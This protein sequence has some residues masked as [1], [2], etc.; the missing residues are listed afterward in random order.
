MTHELL[1]VKTK[2][3]S[4]FFTDRRDKTSPQRMR[5]SFIIAITVFFILQY[6]ISTRFGTLVYNFADWESQHYRIPEYFRNLFYTT[7]DFFPDFGANI[8]AGQNIYNLS[9]YGLYN[10]VILLSYLLPFVPMDIYI[11][12]STGVLV[13]VSILLFYRWSLSHF[14]HYIAEI[15]TVLFMTASPVIFHTHRHMMFINYMPFLILALIGTER[16]FAKRKKGLFIISVCLICLMSYFYSIGAI[17]A[18]AVYGIYCYIKLNSKIKVKDICKEGLKFASLTVLGVAMAAFLLIPTFL[19]LL[20][21]RGDSSAVI[22]FSSLFIPDFNITKILYS[23]YSPGVTAITLYGIIYGIIKLKREKRFL[24]VILILPLFFPLVLFILNGGM[25][26]DGKVLIPM[27]PLYLF[28]TASFLTDIFDKKKI[29]RCAVIIS[30][31]IVLLYVIIKDPPLSVLTDPLITVTALIMFDKYGKRKLIIIPV[32]FI[33]MIACLIAQ[34]NDTLTARNKLK[35]LEIAE[36]AIVHT[37]ETDDDLYRVNDQSGGLN[38]ANRVIDSNHYITS[39]YSSLSNQNYANFYYDEIGNEIRNRSRG[40]L[41]NPNNLLFNLYMGNKY[42]AKE[43]LD[44]SGYECIYGENNINIYKTDYALPIGYSNT[45]IM[46][47]QQYEQLEYPYNAEALL[48][49]I[50]VDK[51]PD[52]SFEPVTKEIPFPSFTVT[53]EN[54]ATLIKENDM[55]KIDAQEGSALT[56]KLNESFENKLVFIEFTLIDTNTKDIGDN[57]I[58]INGITN[59]LP[60]KGW[61]YDNKNYSFQYTF[62][63]NKLDTLN[64]NFKKGSYTLTDIKFY[65]A[66]FEEYVARI[67]DVSP[68]IFDKEK[69]IGD[70]IAGTINVS[71]NGYVNLSVPYDKG[72]T[73][74]LDGKATDYE[75]TDTAFIGFPVSKGE[76]D[77]L[78]EYI[79]PGAN[80]A[81][82]ISACAWVAFFI[83]VTVE[84]KRKFAD[85]KH[86][87]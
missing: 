86:I 48:N 67:N 4:L 21:G 65:T 70:T 59:K 75:M 46:S 17:F 36:P 69:T 74:Y 54:G 39:I 72:F 10:P 34:S 13:Y 76:H 57:Q 19:A 22:T 50:I 47:T 49:Y 61:K 77:I 82:L 83:I 64:F 71:D 44:M 31:I 85:R 41:S 52:C 32:L 3:S 12:I 68:I 30:L 43:N 2:D 80:V 45:R 79:A 8:G 55:I 51:A 6:F 14:K 62:A 16:Y 66:D 24:S 7:G 15:V 38:I 56:M 40:Q 78:I 37:I 28:I 9:Y 20:N 23:S 63:Q 18:I 73:V 26:L 25:Y 87:I 1:K 58:A 29:S 11:Q 60:Y 35:D 42:I 84:Y 27:T 53:K 33:A 81:K 5:R